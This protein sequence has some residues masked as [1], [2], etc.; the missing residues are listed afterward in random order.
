[1]SK[2][3]FQEEMMLLG[4][5][6]SSTRGRTVTF[7][8]NEDSEEHPFKG[9][10][11]KQGKRAGQRF[12]VVGVEIN[13]DET[14]VEQPK[15]PRLSQQAAIL[16]R[17]KLFWQFI[18]ERSFDNINSEDAA[19]SYILNGA[20]ILSRAELDTNKAAGQ[21]FREQCLAQYLKHKQVIEGKVI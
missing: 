4:W 12:M 15:E 7:L 18:G 10:T 6:E 17:D 1:M 8:L 3:A 5:A 2:V 9:F 20:G 21:W 19:R 13:D 11:M 14:A 16:C